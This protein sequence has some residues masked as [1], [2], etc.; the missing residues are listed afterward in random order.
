MHKTANLE[1]GYMGSGRLI[2]RAINKYGI[3]N[4]SK[5]ILHIFDNEKDMKDKEKELVIVSEE[6]YN[7]IEG[8]H[9]GFGYINSNNIGDKKEAGRIGGLKSKGRKMPWVT[10]RLKKGQHINLTNAAKISFKGKKHKEETKR[11]I[12]QKNSVHQLGEGNSQ[13]GTCWV[14]DGINSI[15]IDKKDIDK[16]V[17]LGYYKGRVIKRKTI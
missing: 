4:F 15:K 5:E 12:G 3:E 14:T 1:D 6:T 8:G 7:L 2:K 10:E 17:E 9:G 11:L 13:Y 16:Y